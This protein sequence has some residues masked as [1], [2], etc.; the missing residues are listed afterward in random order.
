VLFTD[1]VGSTELLARLGEADFDDLRRVHFASLRAAVAAVGGEEI[2]TLGDGVLAVFPSASDALTAAVG[3]QQAADLQTRGGDGPVSV[4]VGLALGDLVFEDG[5][6]FGTPVVEAARLVAAARGGQILVT[7]LV[8]AVAGARTTAA[9]IDLEPLELKGIPGPV[10][11]CEV[12]WEPLPERS[13]PLPTFMTGTGRVF[14]GRERDLSRLQE[15]AKEVA[16]GGVRV[17]LIAG[18]PGIGKTRLAAELAARAH[19]EGAL[20]LAGRCDEDL[21]VPFQPFVEALRQFVRTGPAA[22]THLGRFGGDLVR[23]LPELEEAAGALPP[24]LRSDPE[25]ERYRL[26]DAVAVWLS[27]VSAETPVL[28][29]LDDLQWASKPTLLLLRHVTR[30]TEPMRLVVI[31]TFRDTELP[32][33]HPLPELLADLRRQDGVERISLAGLDEGAVGEYLEAAAGH[34]LAGEDHRLVVAIHGETEGNPFFVGE[35]LRHLAETG[36]VVRPDGRW[37][38]TAAV[39]ELGI[40]EG[41]REVIRRRLSRLSEETNRVLTLAAVVGPEFEPAVVRDVTGLAEDA[42]L[43]ALEAARAAR[44]LAE[45]P[46]TDRH[47]F[48]H[49]LVRATLSDELTTARRMTL[50]RRVGEALETRHAG[51]LDDY[52]PSLA[53]HYRAAG[54]A[55]R[56]VDYASRAGRRALS[57]LAFHEAVHYFSQALELAGEDQRLELLLLLGEAQQRT[58]DAGHRETLLRAGELAHER[59]EPQALARAAITNNRWFHSFSGWVDA[60]RVAVAEAAL[61]AIGGE[62]SGM[63]ARLL[64]ILATELSFGPDHELRMRLST[65]AM[66]VARRLGDTDALGDV[67]ARRWTVLSGADRQQ[68]VELQDEITELKRVADELDDPVLAFWAALWGAFHALVRG[69]RS[70]FDADLE[71]GARLADG[72]GQ[73]LYRWTA[74]FSLSTQSR[75]AGELD[76]AER[77]ARLAREQAAGIVDAAH[78]YG[79]NLFWIRYDQGRLVE[80]IDSLRRGASREHRN[81]LTP[82]ALG[83]ALCEVG[84][85]DEAEPVFRELAAGNFASLPSNFLWLYGLTMAAECCAQLDDVEG[86]RRF[87]YEELAPHGPLVGWAGGGLTGCV[88]HYVALLAA[89]LDRLDDA[90]TRFA[91]AAGVHERLGAPALLAR[92]RLEWAQMLLKRARE[93]DGGRAHQLLGQALGTARELGLGTIERR[94]AALLQ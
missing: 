89:G 29:V 88:D 44:L 47:R 78:L 87:L 85:R 40:P 48:S 21:S 46:G 56:T 16:T 5:D 63:R 35:V 38:T 72:L 49:A 91:Q 70:A 62:D 51:R 93:D 36:G 75:I 54:D 58:G 11:C 81:P 67:L 34:Q 28:L 9:F 32:A 50:H 15:L 42:V 64:A 20:V 61:E 1:L 69:D 68:H 52:L 94:A 10:A 6:V 57:Q 79:A 74:G 8:R 76:E 3:I 22:V 59:G 18:E 26:F 90:D 41:V 30:S 17:A 13:V 39:E 33:G 80:M 37:A 2:K 53:H 7:A 23:L 31:G 82:V 45:V 19:A 77:R 14:V 43:D 66:Q 60:E 84:R 71:T 4:R 24:P 83:V 12:G 73:P 65:E 25:T 27:D 86:A 92:T 55:A